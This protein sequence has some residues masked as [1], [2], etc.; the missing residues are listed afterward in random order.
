MMNHSV[1]TDQK[2]TVAYRNESTQTPPRS[3]SEVQEIAAA[4]LFQAAQ[5]GQAV[6]WHGDFHNAKQVLAALKKRV[7]KPAKQGANPAETFHKHRLAQSQQSRLLNSLLVEIDGSGSLK[8]ARAPDIRAALADV[9]GQDN[10]GGFVLPLNQLLG[11]IG[12]HEWH[13]R[14]V[15]IPEI[16]RIRVPYGVF[17]PLRGEYLA[18]LQ[19][20]PLPENAQTAF[21]IGTGSG[22]IAAILAKRGIAQISATDTNPR[23][24]ACAQNNLQALHLSEAVTLLCQD[25]FPEGKAD[26]I[27]CNPPWLPAAPSSALESAL[28]DPKHQM[29]KAFLNGAAAH[30][31]P[32]GQVWLIMSDLAEHLG[33]RGGNELTDWIQAAGLRVCRRIDTKPQHGKAADPTDPL[34]FARMRETT[35]LWIMEAA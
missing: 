35:S 18:L 7:R 20:A 5:S 8:N 25:L 4:K 26:L 23:A 1:F 3:I 29:L 30:L 2:R 24:I 33:L 19:A 16:G 31:Q 12:A 15:E 32:Q 17:S 13:K 10:S 21:D 11:F 14:G 9:Y 28:Y 27:V 6:L 22:I 34:A